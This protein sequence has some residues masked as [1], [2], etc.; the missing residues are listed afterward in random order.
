MAMMSGGDDYL[1]KP[2]SLPLLMAKLQALLRRSYEY[3]GHT[4]IV[5]HESL[6]YDLDKGVLQYGSQEIVL[7]RTEHKI[8]QILARNRGSIVSRE[9]LMMQIWST[10]EFISDGSLTTGISRLKAKLRLYSDED[11]IQTRKK[12]GYLL[13]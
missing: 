2:F 1:Q 13:I 5:L 12:Q 10:D 4:V 7:T 8:L 11:L 3:V 9:D 6:C